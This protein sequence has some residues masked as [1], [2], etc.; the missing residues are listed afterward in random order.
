MLN[1]AYF[2]SRLVNL[3]EEERLERVAAQKRIRKREAINLGARILKQ[4]HDVEEVVPPH[5]WPAYRMACDMLL[6]H[7]FH[8][9]T[10]KLNENGSKLS[11]KFLSLFQL[12][13]TTE[14]LPRRKNSGLFTD[15]FANALIEGG[16]QYAKSKH[17]VQAETFE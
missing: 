16:W 14:Y 5:R 11:E 2:E 9:C 17:D 7:F 6:R 15:F 12:R 8:A 4:L 10:L 1:R 3:K 13:P